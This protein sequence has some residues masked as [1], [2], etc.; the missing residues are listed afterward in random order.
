MNEN[1]AM[2]ADP[3]AWVL[4]ELLAEGDVSLE[5]IQGLLEILF[6]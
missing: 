3:K 1:A 5:L 6:R 2:G 4:E